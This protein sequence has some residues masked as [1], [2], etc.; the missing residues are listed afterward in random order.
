MQNGG[1]LIT[2]LAYDRRDF[3]KKKLG[4]PAHYGELLGAVGQFTRSAQR[5]ES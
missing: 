5:S 1:D 3:K 2:E 4:D